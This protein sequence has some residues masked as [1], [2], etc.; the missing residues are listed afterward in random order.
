[1]AYETIWMSC[2]LDFLSPKLLSL[3]YEIRFSSS[4]EIDIEGLG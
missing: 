1:M 4:S 3:A 2:S